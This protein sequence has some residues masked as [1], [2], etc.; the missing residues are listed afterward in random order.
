MASLAGSVLAAYQAPLWEATATPWGGIDDISQWGGTYPSGSTTGLLSS[1]TATAWVGGGFLQDIAIRD[2]SGSS[3]NFY[4]E[5]AL[6]GGSNGSGITTVYEIDDP[7]GDYSTTNLFADT[8]LVF[9]SQF[10]EK[11]EMSILSGRV[12]TPQLIYLYTET[13]GTL[14]MRDGILHANVL[15]DGANGSGIQVNMLSN[16]TGTITYDVLDLGSPGFAGH[17]VNFDSANLGSITLGTIID[18]VGGT[19]VTTSGIWEFMIANGKVSIDGVVNTN[20]SSYVI[21]YDGMAGTIRLPGALTPEEN[22]AAW[23]AGYGLVATN[24]SGSTTN[25]FEMDGL[26]NL[27][28]YALGGNPTEDDADIINPTISGSAGTLK[29]VYN[30]RIDHAFRGLGYGLTVTTDD[31]TAENWT[32]IGTALES[33]SGPI[34]SQFES[35][36]NSIPTDT[37]IGFVNLEVTPTF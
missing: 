13:T 35:V 22:Y 26:D 4:D 24:T 11:M 31:L 18:P 20:A 2:E 16:G 28:E 34:D 9:W 36:T 15:G 19:N 12:E 27:T 7:D 14:N 6:R 33:G 10:G 29:Y 1:A 21:T 8:K 5:T 25:D 32:P 17:L 37:P 30:R 3:M 23:A